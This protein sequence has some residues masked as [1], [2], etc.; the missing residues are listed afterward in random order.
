MVERLVSIATNKPTE[1]PADPTALLVDRDLGSLWASEN[2][3]R[4]RFIVVNIDV[5]FHDIQLLHT[6]AKD[7]FSL[8]KEE[9]ESGDWKERV[10]CEYGC[11]YTQARPDARNASRKFGHAATMI[12]AMEIAARATM[13]TY[14]VYDKL[15]ILPASYYVD[16]FDKEMLRTLR[17]EHKDFDRDCLKAIGQEYSRK[18]LDQHSQGHT[19]SKYT[20]TKLFSF[21]VEQC[22]RQVGP[23]R[24]SGDPDKQFND[25]G[26]KNTAPELR[27]PRVLVPV[28]SLT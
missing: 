19:L 18:L 4:N 20:A 27:T 26:R 14:S 17:G 2:L 23:V 1:R 7:F 12:V 22:N 16:G 15:R 8:A 21:L 24:N 11:S 9:I 5:V 3:H 10:N 6:K 13:P 25:L 28:P